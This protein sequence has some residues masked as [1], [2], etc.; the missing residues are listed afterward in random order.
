MQI[1]AN[2]VAHLR[3]FW[4]IAFE[5]IYTAYTGKVSQGRYSSLWTRR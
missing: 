2:S 5:M 3:L 1:Q 4:W